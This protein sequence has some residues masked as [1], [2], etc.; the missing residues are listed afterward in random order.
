MTRIIGI[1]LV[2][3]EDRFLE[4]VL[5]NALALCDRIDV[6]DHQSS[7]RTPAVVAALEKT[8]SRVHYQRIESPPESHELVSP[9]AGTPTWIFAVD[10]DEIYD[11]GR[12]RVLREKILGGDLDGYW[13]V[14]GNVLHCDQLEGDRAW[15]YLARP[16]RSMTKL[17]NFGLIEHWEGP[18]SER[19]HGGDLRFRDGYHSNLCLS[20]DRDSSFE[21]SSFRC[22]H[23]VF[24]PRSSEQPESQR[25]RPNIAEKLAYRRWRR[26]WYW[27]A[28]KFGRYPESRGKFE[29]YRRGPRVEKEVSDFFS[30]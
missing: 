20:L 5:R 4:R 15:G 7:D 9:Y 25:H 13:H 16:S 14:L 18:C 22:L 29:N 10:G 30:D 8:D 27:L 17:Y 21:E 23:T 26:G 2:R 28:E 24:L 19:L 12:L 11:P 6:A 1:C 3:N